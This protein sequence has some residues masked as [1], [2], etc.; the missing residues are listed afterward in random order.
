MGKYGNGITIEVKVF[1][2]NA[3]ASETT[4]GGV[5]QN[6]G[7]ARAKISVV[8]GENEIVL[9]DKLQGKVSRFY[10]TT[11]DFKNKSN[12]KLMIN[13]EN[14]VKTDNGYWSPIETSK[15]MTAFL[16][17]ETMK[18]FAKGFSKSDR[19]VA[20]AEAGGIA[21]DEYTKIAEAALAAADNVSAEL[22]DKPKE[23]SSGDIKQ[24][25]KELD[26]EIG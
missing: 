4:K 13:Y 9:F 20:T 3:D 18:A 19:E 5:F 8:N 7:K 2:S 14:S 6:I 10:Q 26:A 22:K 11:E 21:I 1:E 17:I 16:E 12:A 25:D 24:L 15:E 23:D